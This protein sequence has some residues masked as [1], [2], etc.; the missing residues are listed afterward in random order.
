M[1]LGSNA[2]RAAAEAWRGPETCLITGPGAERPL[3]FLAFFVDLLA[4]AIKSSL[5]I[6]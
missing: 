3:E 2:L 6:A 5:W 4:M 1:A